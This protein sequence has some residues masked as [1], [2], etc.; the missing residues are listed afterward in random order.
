MSRFFTSKLSGLKPYTPGEQP[1]DMQYV[2]LNTNES[3]Y[4]PSPKALQYARDAADTLMLY[5]DPE[6]KALCAKLAEVCGVSSN[7]VVVG[8]GSD[9]ILDFAFMAFGEKGVVFPD[10]SYGFYSVFGEL[11][12]ISAEEIPV[13]SDLSIDPDDYCNVGKTIFLANPNAPS[14]I[15]LTLPELERIITNN[16][17]SV[18]VIDEAYVDFG[19]ESAIPL[20][21]K[22]DNVLV[23]QTF[24]KSRSLA[25]ARFGFG[26]GSPELIADL[27]RIRYSTN[28]YNVSRTSAAA[29]LGALEDEKITRENCAKIIATRKRTAETLT[30]LGFT[31]P[32]SSTNF[33]FVKHDKISGKDLYLKLKE[34]GILVRHFDKE[35]ITDYNRITIGTDEQMDILLKAVKEILE[36]NA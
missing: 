5:P 7:Q 35:S 24:S 19:A 32:V 18:V 30:S 11:N 1:Q 33:L 36:E 8:N 25:G 3:P 34:R 13:K 12:R 23:V 22:Y 4:P 10:T 2:K 6:Y 27:N 17:D 29:A 31:G 16:P 20:T 15:A 26:V 21:K 14:G 28:P 9:E